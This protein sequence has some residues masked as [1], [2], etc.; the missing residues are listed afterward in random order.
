MT[1]TA[2]ARRDGIAVEVAPGGA[3]RSLELSQE[4][5][6]AGASR[7]AHTILELV[8]EATAR[9]GQRA[10]LTLLAGL[11]DSET[12]ALGLARD[13]ALTETSEAT[14]PDSWRV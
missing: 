9:A 7:L 12:A 1:I 5:L 11:S 8:D 3:L 10:K 6:R 4:A 2:S 14:T 13:D